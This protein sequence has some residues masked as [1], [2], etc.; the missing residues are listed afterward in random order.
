MFQKMG[1]WK[2]GFDDCFL[3]WIGLARIVFWLLPRRRRSQL[4][5][6]GE[7]AQTAHNDLSIWRT[8]GQVSLQSELALRMF[9]CTS[10]RACTILTFSGKVWKDRCFKR[11]WCRKSEF[12]HT[13]P[14]LA[15]DVS[16][17]LRPSGTS[18]FVSTITFTRFLKMC[19][20]K[21][22]L[23]LPMTIASV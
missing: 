19:S 12:M 17:I 11:R 21:S 10:V 15:M 3:A 18:I 4:V 20:A 7:D 2:W 13:Q 9:S 16:S 8:N 23:L 1:G 6:R 14:S 22:P 5:T